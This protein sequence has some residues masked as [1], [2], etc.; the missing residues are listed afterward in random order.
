MQIANGEWRDVSSRLISQFA[1]GDFAIRPLQT[2]YNAPPE[3]M[4]M[5]D[6]TAIAAAA[7]AAFETSAPQH[8]PRA[9][10]NASPRYAEPVIR[11]EGAL[12]F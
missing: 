7:K 8:K 6:A 4:P 10:R 9:G 3:E 12:R 11:H 1:I 2:G 5:H